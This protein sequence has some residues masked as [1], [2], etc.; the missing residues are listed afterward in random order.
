M[1]GVVFY[2]NWYNVFVNIGGDLEGYKR[3]AKRH[4]SPE[5]PVVDLRGVDLKGKRLSID[6]MERVSA[7][8]KGR[9]IRTVISDDYTAV[10][11]VKKKFKDFRYIVNIPDKVS[12]SPEHEDDES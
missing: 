10:N 7:Q 8:L 2:F 4:I 9:E 5:N 11:V 3:I 6:V 12:E 1:I